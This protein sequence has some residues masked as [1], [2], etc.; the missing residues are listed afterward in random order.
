MFAGILQRER[1]ER[2]REECVQGTMLGFGARGRVWSL[3]IQ[4]VKVLC[5]KGL[6][7]RILGLRV[8]SG[9]GVRVLDFWVRV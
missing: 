4:D 1:V 7:L 5:V 9:C 3:G 8:D 6:G 2:E